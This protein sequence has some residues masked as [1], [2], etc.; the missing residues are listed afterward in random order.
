VAVEV[1]RARF[2]SL[3]E[4]AV[5]GAC[6]LGLLAAAALVYQGLRS[7]SRAIVRV[8]AEEVTTAGIPL[9]DPPAIVPS[10]AVSVPFVILGN[11]IEVRVGE[12]ES[13]IGAKVKAAWQVGADALERTAGGHRLTRVYDDGLRRFLLV[14]DPA[15]EQAEL[16]V[17]AI[18]V[19][20][21]LE[22]ALFARPGP[23]SP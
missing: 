16:R 19:G 23:A 18:Y 11:G 14:F 10:R 5:A 3:V 2:G 21:G 6:A 15:K 20:S 13:S 1:T 4:W 17:S 22:S 12:R 7:T 8:S 9:M